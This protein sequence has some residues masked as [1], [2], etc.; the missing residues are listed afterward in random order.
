MN[1]MKNMK[2]YLNSANGFDI[3]KLKHHEV[4]AISFTVWS[5]HCE[6]IMILFCVQTHLVN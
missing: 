6:C 3:N 1:N 5:N 2:R 4:T